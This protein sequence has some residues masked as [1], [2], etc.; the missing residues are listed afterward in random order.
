VY[1]AFLGACEELRLVE[2]GQKV[3]GHFEKFKAE[4]A[5][6]SETPN[7]E[8][9]GFF[10]RE[11]LVIQR[12]VRFLG[13]IGK[14]TR[15][16]EI[17]EDFAKN[18]ENHLDSVFW[19]T[20]IEVCCNFGDLA[21]AEKYFLKMSETP[22]ISRPIETTYIHL[23][24]ACAKFGNRTFGEKIYEKLSDS[25]EKIRGALAAVV[26]TAFGKFR[27][28]QAA[29][30]KFDEIF[31]VSKS[32]SPRLVPNSKHWSMLLKICEEKK[33]DK[34]A[35]VIFS[36]MIRKRASMDAGNFA[37]ILHIC[38]KSRNLEAGEKVLEILET[39]PKFSGLLK[40]Q[41]VTGS[42]LY[43]FQNCAGYEKTREFFEKIKNPSIQMWNILLGAT[44]IERRLPEALEIFQKILS[45]GKISDVTFVTMLSICAE[46][47]NLDVGKEVHEIF[48]KSGISETPE[49]IRA[50]LLMYTRCGEYDF[51][52]NILTRK[53]METRMPGKKSPN[54][55]IPSK[56]WNTVFSSL[57]SRGLIRE[58]EE[59]FSEMKTHIRLDSMI[60]LTLFNFCG[61]AG[62]RGFAEK[63]LETIQ[64][65]EMESNV[66]VIQGM[67][68]MYGKFGDIG[69]CE[70]IFLQAR[71]KEKIGTPRSPYFRAIYGEM[72]MAYSTTGHPQKMKVLFSEFE[73]DKDVLWYQKAQVA[74]LEGDTAE[75]VK[76]RTLAEGILESPELSTS[77]RRRNK[78]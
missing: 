39:N 15:A 66:F 71:E 38:A 31:S 75:T 45:S 49:I 62:A 50:L 24:G 74:A 52:K 34:E 29:C 72:L 27:G 53:A 23:L 17:F 14:F 58:A 54:F 42:V 21:R 22:E 33:L 10:E 25:P 63:L 65:T 9:S 44:K 26:I 77:G 28:F 40:H 11:V 4:I 32:G 18:P 59:L 20:G 60:L 78:E 2:L 6:R 12:A 73:H 7:C 13:K 41:L 43:L 76:L 30:E 69:T 68:G 61:E 57:R 37:Q 3:L 56:H 47:E 16:I 19:T 64:G 46:A 55:F 51:C 70:K 48:E 5:L 36:E 8:N 1:A 67:I 35:F